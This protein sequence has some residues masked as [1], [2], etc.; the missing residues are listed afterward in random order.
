MTNAISFRIVGTLALKASLELLYANERVYAVAL[1]ELSTGDLTGDV[2]GV[3]GDSLD[4][5]MTVAF[6]LDF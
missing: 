3:P 5:F 1:R 6:V 2:V 4:T